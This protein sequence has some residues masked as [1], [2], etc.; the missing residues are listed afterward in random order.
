M[1]DQAATPTAP[2]A[3]PAKPRKMTPEEIKNEEL[4][5]TGEKICT[6]WLDFRK[7]MRK[8]FSDQPLG[9]QEEQEFLDLKSQLT[10]LQRILTQRLPEAAQ[11]GGAKKM[12]ELMSKCI[13][14]NVIRDLPLQDKK[15]LYAS[16]HQLHIQQQHMLGILDLLK[17]GLKVRFEAD[18]KKTGAKSAGVAK[19]KKDVK[20]TVGTAIGGL[21]TAAVVIWR[22]NKVFKFF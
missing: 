20:K 22:L 2:S 9:M 21:L 3:K 15:G 17:E 14:I 6:L 16:W 5:K 4:F 1:T 11:S 19:P 13:S 10:K 7:H 8:A 18:K 12:T